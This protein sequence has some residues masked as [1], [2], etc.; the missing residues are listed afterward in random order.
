MYYLQSDVDRDAI[1][2][3]L[4]HEG[5]DKGDAV[6]SALIIAF[7]ATQNEF[8]SKIPRRLQRRNFLCTRNPIFSNTRPT[9]FNV[10][11]VGGLELMKFGE[12]ASDIKAEQRE[13]PRSWSRIGVAGGTSSGKR[14]EEIA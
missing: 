14:E 10:R 3:Q 1:I 4:N 13:M 5:T 6:R 11:R 7:I 2:V 8:A 12:S 9:M